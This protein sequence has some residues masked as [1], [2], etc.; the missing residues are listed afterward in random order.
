MKKKII[1]IVIAVAG[2]IFIYQKMG[3]PLLTS[4]QYSSLSPDK[5]YK[6]DVYSDSMYAAMPGQGGAGSHGATIILRN[7]WGWKIGS[8]SGCD[9][10]MDDVNIEWDNKN[11][12]VN[13]ATARTIDLNTGE[14]T[15]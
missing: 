5:K 2:I 11:D 13:I 8:N 7:S 6:V 12:Y 9:I 15:E 14:C 10:L 1:A 3:Q 4:Y